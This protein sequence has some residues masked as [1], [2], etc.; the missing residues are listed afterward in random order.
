MPFF[1][2]MRPSDHAFHGG[3]AGPAGQR[4][5]SPEIVAKS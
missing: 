2:P 5:L 4:L 1:W 3:M